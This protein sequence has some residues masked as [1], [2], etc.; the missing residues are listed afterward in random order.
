MSLNHIKE[1]ED[2]LRNRKVTSIVHLPAGISLQ[3]TRK[4]LV[5]K[6]LQK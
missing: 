4:A 3:K 5:V 2:L 1:A 6:Y